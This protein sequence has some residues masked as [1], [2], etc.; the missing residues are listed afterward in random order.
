MYI[1]A[2]IF[3]S[4]I[5][6]SDSGSHREQTGTALLITQFVAG[7]SYFH[8]GQISTAQL[9]SPILLSELRA[10]GCC[11]TEQISTLLSN[12]GSYPGQTGTALLNSSIVLHGS[13]F[14]LY[15][16]SS[17]KLQSAILAF[18]FFLGLKLRVYIVRHALLHCRLRFFPLIL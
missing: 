7:H 1:A 17:Q 5:L 4:C 13:D 15:Q 18:Y 10:N 12:S 8:S 6:L 2:K 3:Y 9:K 14:L 11:T 16:L